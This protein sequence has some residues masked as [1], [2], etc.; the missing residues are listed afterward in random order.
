MTRQD[1]FNFAAIPVIVAVTVLLI[2]A[3]RSH[4]P[5]K[6]QVNITNARLAAEAA[7]ASEDTEETA[8]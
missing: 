1:K 4:D 5:A 3:F 2:N 8:E 7:Q 6:L